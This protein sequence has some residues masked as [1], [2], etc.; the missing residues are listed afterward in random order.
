VLKH[1]VLLALAA[2]LNAGSLTPKV[3][4]AL[5]VAPS[6]ARIPV[7]V[8]TARQGDLGTLPGTSSYDDKVVYL[9]SV[10]R[11]AQQDLLNRLAALGVEGVKPLWLVSRVALRATRDVILE[12]AARDDVAT[13]WLDDTFRLDAVQPNRAPRDATDGPTWNIERVKADSCW[14]DGY[15]G[16]GIVVGNIDTGVEVTHPAFGGRWR[17]TNGWFDA[18]AGAPTPYDDHDVSH[19]TF[20][21]GLL[22]G[23]DGLGPYEFDIGVAPGA[24]FIAAKAMDAQ[25]NSTWSWVEECLN[26]MADPGRPDVLSNSWGAMGQDTLCWASI[27]R[28]RDLGMFVVFSIGNDGPQPGT[29]GVPG[30]FPTVISVG[31]TDFEDDI[32][33]FSSRGPAPDQWPWNEPASWSRPDWDLI[34]PSVSAPGDSVMSAVRGGTFAWYPGTSVSCPQVAGCGALI[35]QKYPQFAHDDAMQLITNSADHVPQGGTYPNN[36]YGW[37]RLNCRRALDTLTLPAQPFV[38]VDAVRV[39]N[40]GNHNDT[41]DPGESADLVLRLRNSGRFAATNVRG[42]LRGGDAIVSIADSTTDIGLLPALDTVNTASDPFVLRAVSS[43][44]LGYIPN[45]TLELSSAETTWTFAVP[46]QVGV[47]GRELWAARELYGLPGNPARSLATGIAYNPVDNRLYVTCEQTSYI[48]IY[49]SDSMFELVDSIWAP[50]S[51][52]YCYDLAFSP[53][54]TTFWVLSYYLSA[55]RVSKVR[56]DGTVLRRFASPAST[57]PAGIAW[58]GQ[59]G[60][61]YQVESEFTPP[62]LV[63]VTDS[64]GRP[65]DTLGIPLGYSSGARGLTRE[66]TRGNPLGSALVNAYDFYIG[67]RPGSDSAGV[68]M[69]RPE[70]GAVV[71]RFRV[72]PPESGGYYAFHISGIEYDPRDAG[73]WVTF[74]SRSAP[75]H[76]IA[77]FSGFYPVGIREEAGSLQPADGFRLQCRPNPCRDFVRLNLGRSGP[78]RVRM[79]VYDRSGRE[80]IVP[81]ARELSSGDAVWQL[82]TRGLAGGVYFVRLDVAGA[83]SL[84]PLVV[85]R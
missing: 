29:T 63:H 60:R 70:D 66:T 12:L 38:R 1:V 64:L 51:N 21:M 27:R 4:E 84:T 20:T 73:Y 67:G 46:V 74:C 83:E 82:D 10:A 23:G 33:V 35:K 26:W 65:L 47:S 52:Y 72:R 5:R 17:E 55:A 13:V 40:D 81:G 75:Y 32:A 15:T 24:T 58:D 59:S 43:C 39:A 71:A 48:H 54:D 61:L 77:K 8:Q 19:G 11:D 36:N 80:V 78:S 7:I 34:C 30:S 18:V 69:L 68:Y 49:S 2:G 14:A 16:A 56:P 44:P 25:G 28:L 31:A 85:L 6:D 22:T 53:G 79:Q 42:V 76:K 57:W 3:R 41:L 37:G 62:S 45:L 9:R 50:D